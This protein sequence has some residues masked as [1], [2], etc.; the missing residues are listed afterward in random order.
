MDI[1]L[2]VVTVVVGQE[3]L[4]L[5][6]IVESFFKSYADKVHADFLII[7]EK[8]F[9]HLHAAN[10]E[11][12]QIYN[13]FDIYDRI[14]YVDVD[15]LIS[16]RTPNVFAIVPPTHIGAVYDNEKNAE[17]NTGRKKEIQNA[18]LHLGNINW[19]T[20]YINSGVLVL[21][22]EHRNVFLNAELR[23]KMKSA[24]NDQTLINYNIKKNQFPI[25]KLHSKFN[26]MQINGFTSRNIN[27][28]NAKL[29]GNNK[30]NAFILHF[31]GE[32]NKAEHMKK[33]AKQLLPQIGNDIITSSQTNIHIPWRERRLMRTRIKKLKLFYDISE[34]GWSMYLAAH[35]KFLHKHNEKVGIITTPGKF[36]MYRD[37]VNLMLPLPTEY[38][39]AFGNLPSDGNHLFDPISNIR[40]KDHKIL[41]AP[42]KK[43]YPQHENNIIT[44]YSKFENECVFEPYQHSRIAINLCND[45]MKDYSNVI[46][47]FPRC[48]SSKF[49]SRN[50]PKLYWNIIVDALCTQYKNH[51]I[52][53]IGTRDGAYILNDISQKNFVDLVGVDNGKTLDMLVAFCNLK[54]ATVAIGNQSG[55]VKMTLLCGTP[56]FIIGDE[57]QRHQVDENWANTKCGFY[58]C[59]LT[60]TGYTIKD[61]EDLTNQIITFTNT[62]LK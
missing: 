11:K 49:K 62:C 4:Q 46:L 21:S 33:T 41:S 53:S 29:Q 27:P 56:T 40:I 9:T 60:S 45:I 39:Q 5:F 30:N 32:S 14:L 2:A 6:E 58:E 15:I 52:I 22:K 26:G 23:K 3:A 31:A 47:I 10:L 38:K 37:C 55:T 51:L 59:R 7:N 24:Y 28:K 42:F 34:L 19:N 50:I 61:L 44:T 43:A 20:G 25:H 1:K 8:H 35:I 36:V 13:L 16:P 54:Y 17:N 12:F 57:K 48:R 18:Q